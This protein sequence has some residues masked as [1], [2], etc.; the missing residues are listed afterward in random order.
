MSG[1]SHDA[2]QHAFEDLKHGKQDNDLSPLIKDIEDAKKQMGPKEYKA[3]LDELN[4]MTATVLPKLE[5]SGAVVLQ[6]KHELQVTD[7]K[8]HI[9][10]NIESNDAQAL[11]RVKPM[12]EG[13]AEMEA[14]K[15]SHHEK[16]GQFEV[17]CENGQ[18]KTITDKDGTTLYR[19]KDGKWSYVTKDGSVAEYDVFEN[20][21]IDKQG[22]L[23]YDRGQ[24]H[25]IRRADGMTENHDT[26]D[27]TWSLYK[28]GTILETTS[29][30][31]RTRKYHYDKD[32]KLDAIDGNLGHWDRTTDSSGKTE[33]VNKKG[34]LHWKGEFSLDPF[35]DLEFAMHNGGVWR[36]TRSGKDVRENNRH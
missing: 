12:S 4:K 29:G 2:A 8:D 18:V 35:D 34:D 21:K 30:E 22:N 15:G 13:K 7:K 26:S 33:W 14:T 27:G 1:R 36:F 20:V 19:G 28:R 24:N 5:I 16:R 31:G 32:G 25:I 11:D 10:R 3:F 23:S 9:S 6:G 17:T